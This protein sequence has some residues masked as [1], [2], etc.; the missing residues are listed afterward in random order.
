M[1]RSVRYELQRIMGTNRVALIAV[2]LF[3]LFAQCIA[4][5]NL[6]STFSC[7]LNGSFTAGD[8]IAAINKGTHPIDPSFHRFFILDAVWAAP[9]FLLGYLACSAFTKEPNRQA[10]QIVPRSASRIQWMASKLISL[11]LIA[12]ACVLLEFSLAILLA[13]LFN[14]SPSFMPSEQD[15]AVTLPPQFELSLPIVNYLLIASSFLACTLLFAVIAVWNPVGSYLLLIAFVIASAYFDFA[16]LF[17]SASMTIRNFTR[18]GP[19]F[20][21]LFLACI[22][23]LLI[24]VVTGCIASRRMDYK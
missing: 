19:S 15:G 1:I 13:I 8:I 5:S 7:E 24:S 9:Y 21:E 4:I 2:A 20:T 3:F 14:G 11:S 6:S 23:S 10:A 12:I 16:P 22:I 18:S 17:L